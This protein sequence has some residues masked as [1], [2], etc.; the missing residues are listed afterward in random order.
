MAAD[1]LTGSAASSAPRAVGRATGASPRTGLETDTDS[2][3]RPLVDT[4]LHHGVLRTLTSRGGRPGC[5]GGG[6]VC[7]STERGLRLHERRP[8][9]R[10]RTRGRCQ[11]AT[12]QARAADRTTAVWARA[13]AADLRRLADRITAL[14]DLP[15]AARPTVSELHAALAHDDRSDL[16]APLASARLHL[17]G[18][19]PDLT[20]QA[21][22]LT[23]P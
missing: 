15:P 22:N 17:T 11:G 18:A 3:F 2:R 12:R 16:I 10:S 5:P 19:H 4:Q 9:W 7:G 20:A 23:P 1:G 21:D 13:N 8:T 6:G 14:T